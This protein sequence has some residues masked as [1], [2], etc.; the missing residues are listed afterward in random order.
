MQQE[1]GVR[2]EP[3]Q[4][5]SLHKRDRILD[6]A[7][8]LIYQH[9]YGAIA[10]ADVARSAGIGKQT[11]YQMFA[12]KEAILYA[13]CERKSALIDAHNHSR[14]TNAI[15]HGWR[16]VTRAGIESFYDLNRT[17][18]SLDAL[19]IASQD[20]PALR[21]LDFEQTQVRVA[22]AASLFSAITGIAND[23]KFFEFTLTAT[24]T[25]ASIVRHSLMYED[26][27]ARRLIEYHVQTTITRLEMLGAK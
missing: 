10:I 14:L 2:T 19:F 6:A 4:A 5:R 24:I 9:G 22:A 26:A 25:T 13:L 21:Q 18:P 3:R 7:Q 12:N 23:R 8:R 1:Y 15:P 20:V 17:D 16:E 11:L 27:V